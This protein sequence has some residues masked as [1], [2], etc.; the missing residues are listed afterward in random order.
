MKARMPVLLLL[1][2]SLLAC[3]ANDSPL[4]LVGTLERDRLELVAEDRERIVEVLVTEGERVEAGQLLM[5][6]ESALY[7]AQIEEARA[8][9]QRA[10]QRLAELVRG[11][12]EEEIREAR[13]RLAGARE[14]LAVQER[15]HR[16]VQGL[17]DRKL[18]SP[19]DLDRAYDSME[20]ARARVDETTAVLD[21]LVSGTTREELA[22]AEAQLGQQD[23]LIQ[24]LEITTERLRIHAPRA[25]V[26]DALPYKLGERPA[27]GATVIV[28]LA[29][30][31]P[32]ARVYV[33]E[34]MRARVTPGVEALITVDGLG[35][36]YPG[37]V[38]YVAAEAT[39]TPYY[40]LT[41][42]DRSRLAYL[43]EITLDGEA[44]RQLPSGVPVEVDFPSLQ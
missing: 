19:S 43:A 4:P 11:P 7:E 28:M 24:R 2:L 22:Q 42:R 40:S 25:G 3:D 8:A 44:A 14:S 32:Y 35:D 20:T 13:A 38:R 10:E 39:Y 34:P 9:R 5:R 36:S 31:A 12:R 30:M 29:D 15:E 1:A 23:A 17:I 16:R 21:R 37:H 18:A 27:A 6:L 33:P 26:I 41:Q